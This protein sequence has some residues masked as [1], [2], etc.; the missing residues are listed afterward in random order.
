MELNAQ[1][2]RIECRTTASLALPEF[3][4]SALRGAILG[5]LRGL[6]CPERGRADCA[7]CP[8]TGVCPISRL[9]AT[10]DE[11]AS[12]GEEAPRP[13][14]LRPVVAAARML[15]SGDPFSFGLTL[16]GSAEMAFPYLLQGLQAM[17][18]AG[19]GLR[20]RAAGT[21]EVERVL[22]QNPFIA[23][24]Q[25]V[26]ERGRATVY[27]PGLPV[28]QAQISAYAS[29]LSASSLRVELRSPL[30]LVVNG[31]LARRLTM[32]VLTRRL[33]RRL[34]DLCRHF[35]GGP[36][37]ANFE[38]LLAIAERVEVVEDDTKWLDLESFSGRSKRRTPIGGLV[39]GVN[40]SGELAPL[41]PYLAWL[42]VIGLGKDVTKGNGWIELVTR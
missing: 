10:V 22:A 18:E 20:Q 8:F 12:R 41:L 11:T 37:E 36:L 17:G 42:P 29:L 16:I 21:F 28:S 1:L 39:G 33:L 14:V 3:T 38:S 35:G 34:T 32:A 6:F 27:A 9:I 13:Y 5:T 7:P 15:D 2:L 19:F 23:A 24:E 26:Y 31:S 30:R 25:T 4:G 40:F